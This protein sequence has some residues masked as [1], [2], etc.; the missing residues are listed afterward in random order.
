MYPI[1]VLWKAVEKEHENKQAAV[2]CGVD[3]AY[4]GNRY[5]SALATFRDGKL[6][7]VKTDEGLSRSPYVSSLFFLKEGPVISKIIYGEKMDLLFINGH[8]ICHPHRY[9]LATVIGLTH[10]IP[11]IGVAR[12]LIKGEYEKI[13]SPDP[14]IIH[15]TQES[16]ITGMEIRAAGRKRSVFV[17]PGFGITMERSMSEYLRWSPKGKLP[18]PLRIAHIQTRRAISSS[19]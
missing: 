5:F 18:E 8:G 14:D 13:P 17:S 7:S 16:K 9:G 10:Q 3:V 1:Y 12:R 6:F 11:T 15:I 19:K 4:R 2:V